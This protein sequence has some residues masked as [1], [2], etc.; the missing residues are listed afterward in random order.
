MHLDIREILSKRIGRRL[1][2]FI[3]R[4]LEKLIHQDELNGF[5]ATCEGA[6]PEEF[7]KK[8]FEF[9]NVTHTVEYTAPLAD[10]ERYIFASNHPFGGLDG[11]LLVD[12]LVER[13]GDAGAVVNDLLMNIS[14]L[15]PLWIPINKYGKQSVEKGRRYDEAFSSPTKQILTFPAGFCSRYIDSRVQDIEWRSHFVK[16]ALRYNRKIVPVFVEGTLSKRFYRIYRLRR[17][18]HL[19]VNLELVLLVDEMFRQRGNHIHIRVGAPVDVATL[20]GSRGDICKEIRRRAYAL[21]R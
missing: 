14:Y 13:F 10:D 7:L 18:L 6:T 19:N 8:A 21:E 9:L 16:D 5:F 3:S 17:F 4:P 2:K 12:A 15:E 11:M 20:E 1:P